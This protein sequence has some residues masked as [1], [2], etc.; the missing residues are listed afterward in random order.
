M[1]LSFKKERAFT[2]TKCIQIFFLPIK[3]LEMSTADAYLNE[4]V[5]LLTCRLLHIGSWSSIS[6]YKYG[7]DVS[8]TKVLTVYG[9][10][11]NVTVEEAVKH[12]L[13]ATVDK[14]SKYEV[15]IT[16]WV[17]SLGCQDE[18]LFSCAADVPFAVPEAFGRLNIKSKQAFLHFELYI[19]FLNLF[20][21][22]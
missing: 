17:Y 9:G 14:P 21:K 3:G 18:G 16:L 7:S 6:I 11:S 1:G 15:L 12:R 20:F 10:S 13:R 19:Y 4:G 5:T 22:Y 2:N 8:K